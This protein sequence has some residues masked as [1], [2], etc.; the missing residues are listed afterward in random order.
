LKMVAS[1]NTLIIS[2]VHQVF[3]ETRANIL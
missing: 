1:V 2:E 3:W